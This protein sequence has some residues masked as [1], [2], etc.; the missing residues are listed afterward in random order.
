MKL[1]HS[2]LCIIMRWDIL[3]SKITFVWFPSCGQS[4]GHG[5]SLINHKYGIHYDIFKSPK[6]WMRIHWV[7][8]GMLLSGMKNKKVKKD[9]KEKKIRRRSTKKKR[10]K[11]QKSAAQSQT[12]IEENLLKKRIR[13]L[14]NIDFFEICTV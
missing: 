12:L 9:K 4:F 10:R 5:S 7:L 11:N 3:V 14:P 8:I 1:S 13:N 2:Q 6:S